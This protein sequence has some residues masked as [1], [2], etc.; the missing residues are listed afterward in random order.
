MSDGKEAF[1]A[2]IIGSGM[3]GLTAA[4]YCRRYM[5]STAVFAREPGGIIT[6]SALVE[7][8]PGE[9]AISGVE[10]MEKVRAH[11]ESLGARF[12]FGEVE[13]VTGR[14]GKYLR[15]ALTA[16]GVEATLRKR[17]PPREARRTKPPP[18]GRRART[19]RR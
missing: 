12:I 1:D 15:I 10:L 9:K 5:L 14:A 7:N 6:E 4:I 3:A 19:G 18:S 11:A 16:S 8:W 13:T 17:T 2:A